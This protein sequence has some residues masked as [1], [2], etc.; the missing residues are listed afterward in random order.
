MDL[1]AESDVSCPHCGEAFPL[2]VDTSVED[3]YFI[4]DCSVCCRPIELRILSR[5]GEVLEIREAQES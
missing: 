5:P 1:M 4:E 2:V 3:Q